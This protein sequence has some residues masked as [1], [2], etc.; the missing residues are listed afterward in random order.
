MFVLSKSSFEI[1]WCLPGHL[2]LCGSVGISHL[3]SSNLK[4]NIDKKIDNFHFG[5]DFFLFMEMIV[6]DTIVLVC[7][8]IRLL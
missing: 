1:D 6:L 4:R 8:I 2:F 3:N 7:V 5:G